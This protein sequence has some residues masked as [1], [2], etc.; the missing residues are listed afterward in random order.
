[1]ILKKLNIYFFGMLQ[2]PYNDTNIHVYDIISANERILQF[3]RR[4]LEWKD[5]TYTR[6][7]LHVAVSRASSSRILVGAITNAALLSSDEAEN[8]KGTGNPVAPATNIIFILLQHTKG[9]AS[10]K[11]HNRVTIIGPASRIN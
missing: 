6:I 11:K 1:M 9:W 10:N 8:A 3:I 5:R 2:V 4:S 7:P